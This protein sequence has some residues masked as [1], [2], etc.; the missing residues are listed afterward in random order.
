MRDS[1]RFGSSFKTVNMYNSTRASQHT[2]TPL[3]ILYW[4]RGRAE[5]RA[6]AGVVMRRRN[7]IFAFNR[8]R[9][10]SCTSRRRW[11][12]EDGKR[13]PHS[14][15]SVPSWQPR[16]SAPG[17]PPS[18]FAV[19][20]VRGHSDHAVL[21]CRSPSGQRPARAGRSPRSRSRRCSLRTRRRAAVVAEGVGGVETR[22]LAR[23]PE[24]NAKEVTRRRRRVTTAALRDDSVVAHGSLPAAWSD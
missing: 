8:R 20:D 22:P 7:R 17:P 18:Q 23:P 19:R 3:T 2:L 16:Y 6:G 1:F 14:A 4:S 10:P 11:A 5:L 21:A 24:G 13:G 15:Q 12:E 9:K